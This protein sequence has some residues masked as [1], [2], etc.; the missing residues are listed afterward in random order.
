MV[1]QGL[2]NVYTYRLY[3]YRALTT[4]MVTRHLVYCFSKDILCNDPI[5]LVPTGDMS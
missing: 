2:H 1:V 4:T 5:V 3:E